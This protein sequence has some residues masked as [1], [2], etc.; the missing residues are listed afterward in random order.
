MP[1]HT[2]AL[3]LCAAMA[4]CSGPPLAFGQAAADMTDPQVFAERAAS[5]N[6]FEIESSQL[7]LE[8]ATKRPVQEFA[9]HMIEDHTLAGDKM[10]AAA[11]ADGVTPPAAMAEKEQ[12]Q[13]AELEAAEGEAFDEAYVAAQVAAHDEAVALFETFSEQGDGALRDFAAETLPT[14]QQ[15]QTAAHGLGGTAQ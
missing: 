4:L 3:A 8:R 14:L 5:S 2:K 12:A 6:M 9:Q 10:K 7:A 1:M 13:L 11:E 15:H